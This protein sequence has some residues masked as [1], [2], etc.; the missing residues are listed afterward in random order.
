MKTI[1]F[2]YISPKYGTES[3]EAIIDFRSYSA[4]D[5][6][7][8]MELHIYHNEQAY[9]DYKMPIAVEYFEGDY[10]DGMTRADA[11]LLVME[12][13]SGTAVEIADR[14]MIEA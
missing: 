7:I 14:V 9:R 10:T 8:S 11:F 3:Q 6:K 2:N 5:G 12:H 1:K 13:Y 4:I